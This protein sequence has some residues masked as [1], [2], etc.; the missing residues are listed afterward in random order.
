MKTSTLLWLMWAVLLSPVSVWAQSPPAND[1]SLPGNPPIL[2]PGLIT[3]NDGSR[4]HGFT[5]QA[6]LG[7]GYSIETS[8]DLDSWEWVESIPG[9]GQQQT[10]LMRQ[11]PPEPAAPIPPSAPPAPGPRPVMAQLL[12][13]PAATG[14]GIVLS[15][16]SLDDGRPMVWSLPALEPAAGWSE[17]PLYAR[18]FSGWY[19]LISHPDQ[20]APVPA[21]NPMATV[22][23]AAMLAAFETAFPEMNA[24]VL[25]SITRNQSPTTT[26]PAP[27]ERRFYRVRCDWGLDSDSDGTPD[28]M[29]YQQ[30]FAAAAGTNTVGGPAANPLDADS[31]R[32]GIPDGAQRS[33]DGDNIADD[34]DADTKDP[35]IDWA[36]T[37]VFRYATFPLPAPGSGNEIPLQINNRGEVLLS[38]N[39]LWTGGEMKAL[40]PA[41]GNVSNC[42]A[43]AMDDHGVIYG[44]G[45]IADDGSCVVT[46]PP[47]GGPPTAAT[48]GDDYL[49]P[50]ER[51]IPTP[52]NAGNLVTLQPDG[53]R[54]FV[55][56]PARYLPDPQTGITRLIPV[57]G[58][59]GK[60][61]FNRW[62]VTGGA[63]F[64]KGAAAA[65]TDLYVA[66]DGSPWGWVPGEPGPYVGGHHFP[67][68]YQRMARL[69]SGNLIALSSASRP[70]IL[71]DGSWQ[72]AKS[73]TNSFVGFSANGGFAV[74]GRSALWHN[75]KL[76]FLDDLTPG[77][78]EIWHDRPS[79]GAMETTSGGW[80][81][82]NR[83]QGYQG[84]PLLES[85][86]GLPL[87]LEDDQPFTGLDDVSL[88]AEKI[89]MGSAAANAAMAVGNKKE[90]WVM[91]PAGGQS[92]IRLKSPLH[93]QTPAIFGS[94]VIT[95]DPQ[96]VSSSNQLLTLSAPASADGTSVPVKIK[97]GN[98]ESTS[99]PLRA[100]IMKARTLNVMFWPINRATPGTAV[101]PCPALPSKQEIETF[102]NAIF[103]P[104]LNLTVNVSFH[105]P[106]N[107]DYDIA[108]NAGANLPPP[109]PNNPNSV[110]TPRN[111]MFDVDDNPTTEQ[112]AISNGRNGGKINVYVVGGAGGLWPWGVNSQGVISGGFPLAG[113]SSQELKACWIGTDSLPPAKPLPAFLS[114]L[115]HE[116]GHVMIG[117]GHPNEESGV[118]PLPLTDK[119]KRLM[120]TGMDITDP[121]T[122]RRQ[123]VKAE[124]DAAEVWMKANLDSPQP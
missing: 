22:Q 53:S 34:E 18:Q 99:V 55:A 123:I 122:Q 82:L 16:Q 36:K 100:K 94:D 76:V 119:T 10:V 57:T 72:E 67:A 31:D 87:F 45:K 9:A 32:D 21:A 49:H 65:A 95:T 28:W 118:A 8:S 7:L 13:Q 20:P 84:G 66:P 116:I 111:G 121:I 19:F 29:E 50:D 52:V 98:V 81:L 91:V 26:P 41:G 39:K 106:E 73:M 107:V 97:I 108:D 60:R 59:D 79:C 33:S 86:V 92:V 62:K 35:L 51:F 5:F 63:T 103:K 54:Q 101:V 113:I 2:H 117:K 24:D 56:T 104:Q 102:L 70:L 78:P 69:P 14:G 4:W 27:G 115:A 120:H 17:V 85:A 46:W 25:A 75:G 58:Q 109:D 61:V 90:F 12:M 11:A 88:T 40:E 37:P 3:C 124:W 71:K 93:S 112:T 6:R 23:D 42:I 105:A 30:I 74:E 44:Q 110:V 96:T 48:A 47:G 89:T 43:S 1:E 15:W 80:T 68:P 77:M 114:T 83:Y 38:P 64:T